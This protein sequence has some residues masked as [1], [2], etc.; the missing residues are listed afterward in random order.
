MQRAFLAVVLFAASGCLTTVEQRWCDR[1]RPCSAGFVC[2]PDFHCILAPRTDGGVGGGAGGGTGGGGG[3]G[4]GP[5]GGGVGGGV[6]VGGG[7]GGGMGGGGG[8]IGGGVGGGGTPIGGGGGGMTC[9]LVNCASGCCLNERCVPISVQSTAV[10]GRNAERCTTCAMGQACGMGVCFTPGGQDAGPPG[11]V[12]SPCRLDT[13]CGTD[14]LSFCIPENSGGQPT[15][16]VG[17]YCSRLCDMTPCPGTAECVPAE[18]G[19]GGTVNICIASCM[20]DSQCRA[21]YICETGFG[22][23]LCLP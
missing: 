7:G 1:S 12:G 11:S 5:L 19:S 14:G 9:N 20:N 4:G 22:A 6:P 8:P 15:G 23:G 17:G 3:G 13:E 10:C 16:F 21:G 2:T 18:D